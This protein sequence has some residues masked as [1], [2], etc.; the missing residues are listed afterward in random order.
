LSNDGA[1][2]DGKD[3]SHGKAILRE[4]PVGGAPI[5]KL[6]TG[7]GEQTSD[8]V[9][10]EAKQRTQR[11]GLRAVGEAG[12]LEGWAALG[13]ELLEVGEDTNGV[14]FRAEGG[15]LRRRRARRALSSISHST[16]SPRENSMAWA[17]AEGKLMY[18]CSLVW[19]LMS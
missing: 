11:E 1:T 7:G 5:L 19:R 16:V 17:T 4:E 8:G 15:G 13:E 3:I 6:G 10:A 18:H 2:D 14:F 12:L 9:T